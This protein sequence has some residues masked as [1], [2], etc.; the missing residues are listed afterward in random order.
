MA[1]NSAAMMEMTFMAFNLGLQNGNVKILDADYLW[2]RAN[3]TS[4]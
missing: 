4:G 2:Q 1:E 3:N